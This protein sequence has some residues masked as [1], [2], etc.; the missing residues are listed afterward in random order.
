MQT[1]PVSNGILRWQD[2]SDRTGLRDL[3][4][5]RQIITE[6]YVRQCNQIFAV[7]RIDRATTDQSIKDVLDL[8]NRTKLSN[9]SVI[10]TRSEVSYSQSQ[11]QIPTNINISKANRAK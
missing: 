10:C 2:H 5:A 9:V 6:R 3:N 11:N 7:A 1:F 4:S 8:A